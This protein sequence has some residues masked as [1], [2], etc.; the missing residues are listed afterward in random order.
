MLLT[1]LVPGPLPRLLPSLV[2]VFLSLLSVHPGLSQERGDRVL[3]GRVVSEDTGEPLSNVLIELEAQ[4]AQALTDSTGSF[5]MAGIAPMVDT[6]KASYFNLA[7]SRAPVDLTGAGPHEIDLSLSGAAFAVADLVVQIRGS[8]WAASQF[9]RRIEGRRGEIVF[10]PEI[11]RRSTLRL[12][13]FFRT[14]RRTR[15]RYEQGEWRLFM[16]GLTSARYCRPAIFMNGVPAPDWVIDAST[17]EDVL[18]LGRVQAVQQLRRGKHLD[19]DSRRSRR[20]LIR[21]SDL[22]ASSRSLSGI[23][24]APS[25]WRTSRDRRPGSGWSKGPAWER[26]S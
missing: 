15:V 21:R 22:D 10:Y 8:P 5:R 12:I 13:D 1:D 6:V 25:A 24:R 18:A 11:R 23:C 4:G 17:V 20:G 19:R 7:S 9:A 3:T 16:R 14:V 2:A 26:A